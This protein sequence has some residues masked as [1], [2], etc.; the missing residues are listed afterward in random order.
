MHSQSRSSRSEGYANWCSTNRAH[1][2][3]RCFA[4]AKFI[5]GTCS[6]RW[7]NFWK[8]GNVCLGSSTFFAAGDTGPDDWCLVVRKHAVRKTARDGGLIGDLVRLHAVRVR[9]VDVAVAKPVVARSPPGVGPP[10]RIFGSAAGWR[11]HARTWSANASSRPGRRRSAS[12]GASTR[13]RAK[14]SR[15]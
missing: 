2:R 10:W 13:S 12:C 8:V 9:F 5:T 6:N 4:A 14:D 15:R 3:A 1:A 7:S 11:D